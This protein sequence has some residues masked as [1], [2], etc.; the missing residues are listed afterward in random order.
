MSG[1]GSSL[2]ATLLYV[3][4]GQLAL[5]ATCPAF[6]SSVNVS[7]RVLY[8]A[9]PTCPYNATYG[10]TLNSEQIAVGRGTV[11]AC[12]TSLNPCACLLVGRAHSCFVAHPGHH[13]Y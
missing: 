13:G 6:G 11:A 2:D 10:F 12:L 8:P 1:G 5:F 9:F 7:V 4:N 3:V